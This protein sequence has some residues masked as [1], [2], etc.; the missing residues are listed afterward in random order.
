M[1]YQSYEDYMRNVLGY[2]VAGDNCFRNSNYYMNQM[3]TYI[4]E[5]QVDTMYPEI[6]KLINPIVCNV[7]DGFDGNITEDALEKMVDEIYE[8]VELN[9]EIMSKIN[10]E[11]RTTENNKVAKTAT[12]Q[13]QNSNVIQN[14]DVKDVAEDRRVRRNPLLRDLIRILILNRLLGGNRP[15]KRPPYP[16]PRPPYGGSNNYY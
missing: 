9:N 10:V 5:T 15:P 12:V 14:R 2:P 3:P 4:N 6:Y 16:G 13:M 1:Y 8:K 11:N 7:C